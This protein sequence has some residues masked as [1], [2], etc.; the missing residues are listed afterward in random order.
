MEIWL[1]IVHKDMATCVFVCCC[2]Y[3]VRTCVCMCARMHMYVYVCVCICMCVRSLIVYTAV[4]VFQAGVIRPGTAG[5]SCNYRRTRG[6][7]CMVVRG[8]GGDGACWCLLY[9]G[10]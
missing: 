10:A 5:Q 7:G 3:V 9:G 2:V 8:G 4:L 6:G 1:C